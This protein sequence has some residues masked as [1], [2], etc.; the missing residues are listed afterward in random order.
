MAPICETK[1][2][3]HHSETQN[4][5]PFMVVKRDGERELKE[6]PC[7][8]DEALSEAVEE[9]MAEVEEAAFVE[10]TKLVQKRSSF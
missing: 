4:M 3:T 2:L 1:S 10:I 6:Y 9:R 5:F 7:G 8:F